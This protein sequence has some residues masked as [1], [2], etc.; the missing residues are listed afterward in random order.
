MGAI[1]QHH[2]IFTK[3]L[4][5]T[6]TTRTLLSDSDG[7]ED[8]QVRVRADAREKRAR[9]GEVDSSSFVVFRLGVLS[10][11]RLD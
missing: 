11:I 2:T 1:S 5:K 10:E 8:A 3:N 6:K 4:A 7:C 9:S